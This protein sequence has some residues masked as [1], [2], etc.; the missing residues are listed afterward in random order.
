ML[1]QVPVEIS[2]EVCDD[3][4]DVLSS[5]ESDPHSGRQSQSSTAESLQVPLTSSMRRARA[6]SAPAQE[7]SIPEWA[8]KL[9]EEYNKS[10]SQVDF[11]NKVQ[12]NTTDSDC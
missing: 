8:R 4:S 5:P 7:S 12:P 11:N 10:I 1:I 9:A 6:K 2:V 3:I